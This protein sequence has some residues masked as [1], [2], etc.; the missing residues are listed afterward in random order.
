MNNFEMLAASNQRL[1]SAE[2]WSQRIEQQS[3]LNGRQKLVVLNW[4]RT[5]ILQGRNRFNYQS[6]WA[7]PEYI[8]NLVTLHYLE[9]IDDKEQ[10]IGDWTDNY[11]PCFYF[12]QEK[13]NILMREGDSSS[14]NQSLACLKGG[15]E[16]L[17]AK[18]FAEFWI[19][20]RVRVMGRKQMNKDNLNAWRRYRFSS[21]PHTYSKL[22]Q[23]FES[24]LFEELTE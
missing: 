22:Q 21:A 5:E 17:I 6:N 12:F 15:N 20:A 14:E 18:Q 16:C 8:L 3:V 2:K 11:K 7:F 23:V 4:F 9:N 13:W 19:I 1:D 24:E 10:L